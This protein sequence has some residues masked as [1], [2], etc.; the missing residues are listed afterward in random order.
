MKEDL[1][2]SKAFVQAM[3][4]AYPETIKCTEKHD[5]NNPLDLDKLI[6]QDSRVKKLRSCFNGHLMS[7]FYVIFESKI[8]YLYGFSSPNGN[9]FVKIECI[10]SGFVIAIGLNSTTED[11]TRNVLKSFEILAFKRTCENE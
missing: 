11:F 7:N 5:E 6:D 4:E 1:A 8:F 2:F 10:D 9:V 3:E